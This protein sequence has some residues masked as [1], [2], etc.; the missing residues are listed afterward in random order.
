MRFPIR[1]SRKAVCDG[2]VGP[3]TDEVGVELRLL[4]RL[5]SRTLGLL[6]VTSGGILG[7]RRRYI[8]RQAYRRGSERLIAELLIRVERAKKIEG[9]SDM[10]WYDLIGVMVGCRVDRCRC[11]VSQG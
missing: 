3:L 2:A 5:P 4:E 11:I 1:I 9:V 10:I 6:L 8:M 7:V